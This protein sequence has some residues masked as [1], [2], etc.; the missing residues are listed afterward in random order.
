MTA[1]SGKRPRMVNSR[2]R[3]PIRFEEQTLSDCFS[4]QR[5]LG[6]AAGRM[7]RVTPRFRSEEHIAY[8][9]IIIGMTS[10]NRS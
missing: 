3:P 4:V 2:G 5:N 6:T 10:V 1:K 8:K 9:C 7:S